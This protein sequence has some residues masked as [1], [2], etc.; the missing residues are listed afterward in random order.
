MDLR[1]RR[2]TLVHPPTPCFALVHPPAPCFVTEED[3]TPRPHRMYHVWFSVSYPPFPIPPGSRGPSGRSYDVSVGIGASSPSPFC[4]ITA[5][6]ILAVARLQYRR[7]CRN[8]ANDNAAIPRTLMR[9]NADDGETPI[10]TEMC[11]GIPV[12]VLI[13]RKTVFASSP[14]SVFCCHVRYCSF[15]AVSTASFQNRP[16]LGGVAV[17][18][19]VSPRLALLCH[20]RYLLR[21]RR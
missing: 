10:P 18:S 13:S 7:G 12:D 15:A 19:T 5:R 17:G 21:R 3:A 1:N 14:S 2:E 9:R 6:G 4:Y 11:S 16:R 20:R 8:I